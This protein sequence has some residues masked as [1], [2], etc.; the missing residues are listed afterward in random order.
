MI[1]QKTFQVLPPIYIDL[2]H[3]QPPP[4]NLL[5]GTA[6]SLP[7][8]TVHSYNFSIKSYY[9]QIPALILLVYLECPQIHAR[10]FVGDL[11]LHL[12]VQP[13]PGATRSERWVWWYSKWVNGNMLEMALGLLILIDSRFPGAFLRRRFPPQFQPLTVAQWDSLSRWLVPGRQ[14]I[15]VVWHQSK[16]WATTRRAP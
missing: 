4:I 11:V 6:L 2:G 10:F 1:K 5:Y 15:P 14:W 13:K 12:E 16:Q 7:T 9:Q 3:G 8:K